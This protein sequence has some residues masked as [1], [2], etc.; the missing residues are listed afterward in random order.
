VLPQLKDLPARTMHRAARVQ[1]LVRLVKEVPGLRPFANAVPDSRPAYY[2]LGFFFDESAFGLSRDLF[3]KAV[4]AE[5]VAFDAGFRA[6]HVG[7]AA[8]RYRAAG[9]LPHAE[10]A[11]GTVVGLHHPVLSLGEADVEQV[12]AAVRKAYRNRARLREAFEPSPPP[13]A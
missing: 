3:V 4:R 6:L 9:P 7:R 11:G 8:A 1:Q 12:A 13:A 2:K 10:T 5:G